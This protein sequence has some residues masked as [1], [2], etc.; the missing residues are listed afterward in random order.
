MPPRLP[1]RRSERATSAWATWDTSSTFRE[2][3]G[4]TQLTYLEAAV[5]GLVQGVSEMFPV[6]SLGHSVLIPAIIGGSWAQDL[7]VATAESPHPAFV[8]GLHVATAIALLVYFWRDWIR[9]V[10]G[11]CTSIRDRGVRTEDQK[12]AWMIILA[13]IPVGIVGL[14]FEHAFRVIFARPIVAGVFLAVN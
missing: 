12:L 6:S 4:M 5:V 2:G 7:N 8:V 13:T 3:P 10:G 9:I 1:S 11:F 14:L